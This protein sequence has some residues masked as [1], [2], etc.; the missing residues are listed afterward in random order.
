MSAEL[1]YE[2]A[3][4]LGQPAVE[5]FMDGATRRRLAPMV[6]GA[7]VVLDHREG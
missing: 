6:T 3:A 7:S 4:I 5:T 2:T 1:A